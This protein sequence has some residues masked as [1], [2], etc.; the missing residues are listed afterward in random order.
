LDMEIVAEGV[1]TIEQLHVLQKLGCDEVQ[2][3][4]IAR[5]MS[6]EEITPLMS[7]GRGPG[8]GHLFP[9]AVPETAISQQE[10]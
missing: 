3:F 2:G 9:A 6:G 1:E 8:R 10:K 4:Y 7:K 5:P